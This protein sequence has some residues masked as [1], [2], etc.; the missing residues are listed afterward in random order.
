MPLPPRLLFAV[1]SLALLLAAS[2]RASAQELPPVT[3]ML[4]AQFEAAVIVPDLSALSDKAGAFEQASGLGLGDLQDALG[5]FKR[6]LGLI[7]GIDDGGSMMV[8]VTELNESALMILPV[9]DYAALAS[10]LGAEDAEVAAVTLPGGYTGAMKQV[11]GYAVLGPDAVEVGAYAPGDADAA[12]LAA[13]MGTEPAQVVASSQMSILVS[14]AAT[15]RA[16]LASQIALYGVLAVKHADR[17]IAYELDAAQW[18]PL[19]SSFSQMAA[20][21]ADVMAVGFDFSDEGMSYTEAYTLN[22]EAGLPNL[23][24][25]RGGADT[26]AALAMLPQGDT[27]AAYAADPAG[28][29]IAALADRMGPLFG[30]DDRHALG[31]AL[32]GL[33]ALIGQ[34]D[35]VAGAYYVLPDDGSVPINRWLNTITVFAVQDSAG[36]ADALEAQLTSLND[37]ELAV[38]GGESIT[39]TASYKADDRR[40]DNTRV[41]TFTLQAVV[42]PSMVDTPIMKAVGGLAGIGVHGQVAVA[43]GRVIV[44]TFDDSSTLLGMLRQTPSSHGLGTNDALASVRE[45]HLPEGMS[46]QAYLSLDG[47]AGTI[48]PFLS[49]MDA[50]V[51]IELDQSAGPIAVGVRSSGDQLMLR[52]F[53]PSQAVAVLASED[54]VVVADA[55][56]ADPNDPRGN[57]RGEPGRPSFGPGGPGLGPGPSTRP[58]R[59]PGTRPGRDT[60]SRTPG[61]GRPR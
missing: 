22:S 56:Q 48:N 16:A 2:P 21:S 6:D 35:T 52:V 5:M 28:V 8:V 36:F 24:P 60:P 41:D 40:I 57:G 50:S 9:S 10:A 34:A 58:G 37:T 38:P 13:A 54:F 61:R 19:I 46:M 12:T 3:T 47:V 1:L 4:P 42:P 14:N 7:D 53:I 31:E 59:T 20:R 18:S 43:D 33:Q 11:E 51:G 30:L 39:F 23:F 45:A 29:D 44:A 49:M 27:V 25:G 17:M 15:D 55:Q 26:T 32:P